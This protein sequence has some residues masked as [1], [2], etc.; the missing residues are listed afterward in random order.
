MHPLHSKV[1][2]VPSR[3]ILKTIDLDIPYSEV[4]SV[5]RF[6]PENPPPLSGRT[7]N[8]CAFP[9]AAARHRSNTPTGTARSF[10]DCIHIRFPN[11]VLTFVFI[12]DSFLSFRVVIDG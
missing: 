8:V 2:L 7:A 5:A 11:V 9:L 12:E 1:R 6:T 3:F 4:P 10:P